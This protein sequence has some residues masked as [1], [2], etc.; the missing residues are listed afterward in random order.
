MNNLFDR[1]LFLFICGII[2][3]NYPF[4]TIFDKPILIGGIPLIV[5]YFLG[6]WFISIVVIFIFASLFKN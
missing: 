6:G 5:L 4:I 3:I 2:C 1:W